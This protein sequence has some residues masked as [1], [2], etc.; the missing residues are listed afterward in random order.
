MLSKNVVLSAYPKAECK[1]ITSPSGSY[2]MIYDLGGIF[3]NMLGYS[4]KTEEGAWNYAA[5]IIGD[6]MLSKLEN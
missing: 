1:E 2:Y 6:K 3:P 5:T 4:M